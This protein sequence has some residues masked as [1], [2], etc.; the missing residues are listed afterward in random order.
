MRP[1]HPVAINGT[2]NRLASNCLTP[3]RIRR[4]PP[5]ELCANARIHLPIGAQ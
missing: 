1:G 2:V 5:N 3:T 4:S